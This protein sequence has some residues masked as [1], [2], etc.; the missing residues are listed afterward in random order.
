MM[1]KNYF[2]F[3]LLRVLKKT[4]TPLKSKIILLLS[5][6]VLFATEKIVAQDFTVIALPDTQ[7]Y[8]GDAVNF[9]LFIDQ[10]QW[11]LD[12]KDTR[13]IV[14]V[15][16]LGDI[17][18]NS[19]ATEWN[20]AKQALLLLNQNDIAVG[21]APGNHDYNAIFANTGPAT[22]YDENLPATSAIATSDGFGITS[23]EAHEWY[24]G[25]MGGTNDAV[26]ADDPANGNYT[27]RLWKNNYI[28]F[29]AGGMDFINIAL[30]FDFPF[31]VEE[32][33][34]DVLT[35]FPNRRAI[36][37][38]HQFLEDNNNVSTDGAQQAVL[39]NIL[40]DHCNVFL[41]LSAHNHSGSDATPG[42]AYRMETNSCGEPVHLVMSDY[43]DRPNDGDGWLRIMTFRPDSDEIDVETYS[44]TR[45]SGTGDYETDASSQFTLAYDMDVVSTSET[46]DISVN[47]ESDDAEE[48][49]SSGEVLLESSDLEIGAGNGYN[50][51][52]GTFV[53][54]LVG[55]RFQNITVPEGATITN[56]YIQFTAD[57]AD[58]SSITVSIAGE[59]S[60]N[61][62]TFTDTDGD[63]S[64][65]TTTTNS[66]SWSPDEWATAGDAGTAQQTSDITAI[67]QEIIGI[68]GWSSGNAMAFIISG[69]TEPD[70]RESESFD[71]TA[72]PTLHIEYT[73]GPPLS[74]PPTVAITAPTDGGTIVDGTNVSITANATDDVGVTQVAFFVD[75][76]LIN[77]DTSSPYATTN[78]FADGEHTIKAVSTDGD[79]QTATDE[80]TI[81]IGVVAETFMVQVSNDEDDAEENLS[82]NSVDNGSS[83]LEMIF[84]DG[85]S[86]DFDQEVGMRFQG[87]TVP[88]GATITSAYL[89]FTSD[90]SSGGDGATALTIHGQDDDNPDAFTETDNNITNRTKT[91]A[92]VAWNPGT[93]ATTTTYQSADISTILQEIV[94]R[95]GW[96][97]GNSMVLIVTGN[98]GDQVRAESHDGE[99]GGDDAPRLFIEY[100]VSVDPTINISG[101]PLADF[102]AEPNVDSDEQSYTVAGIN[103]T[104][105]IVINAP[106]DFQISLTSGSGFVSSLNLSPTSNVVAT[107][108]IFVKFNRA[109]EGNSNGNITHASAGA[110]QGD[111]AVNGDAAIAPTEISFQEG[112][113]NGYSNTLD[114]FLE[115]GDDTADNSATTTLV[116]DL[117]PE[118]HG[119]LRFDAIFGSGANQIPLGATIQNASLDIEVS[120][121]GTGADLHRMLQTWNDTDSWSTWTD[122]INAD[123][124]EAETTAQSSSSGSDV[125]QSSIDVTA[126]LQAWSNG[127]S[128]FGWAWLPPATDNSWRFDSSENTDPPKLTVAYTLPLVS[129]TIVLSETSLADF[130]AEPNIDSDEQSYT[131]SGSDLTEDI[132][133]N[134]PSDFQISLTSGSGFVSSLNVSPTGNVVASTTIFVK[135]NRTTE[136]NSNGNITH[137]SASASQEDVA[138]NG[139]AVTAS[140][141][142]WIAYNDL[143]NEDGGNATNVTEHDFENSTDEI[144]SDYNSGTALN[145]EM[146]VVSTNGEVRP[147][148]GE[149]TNTASDAYLA[150]NGIVNQTGVYQVDDTGD[151]STITFN[152]LDPSK[153]YEI[154]L[155]TNRDEADYADIRYT[156]VTIVDAATAIN[157]SSTGVIVNSN[158]SVSFSTGYNTLNGY[159]AKWTGIT[160][161][162]NG[163]F[164][165]ASVWDESLGGTDSDNTKGYAMS[166]FKLEQVDQPIS[167]SPTV[168][169][170]APAEGD[171]IVDGTNVSITADATDDVSVS[172]VEF[173]VDDVSIGT[174]TSSPYAI[175]N[176]FADGGHTIKAVSTDGEGQTATDEITITVG[177]VSETLDIAVSQESDDAEEKNT[178]SGAEEVLLESSDLELC[179][180]DR[181]DSDSEDYESQFVGIRFQNITIPIGATI[182]NAY[183]QFTADGTDSDAVSIDIAGE[184]TNN[185][186]TFTE[187]DGDISTR[188]TTT[189]TVNWSPPEWANEGDAGAAQQTSDISDIVQ[190]IINIAGWNS[191]NAMTF[192]LSSSGTSKREP[193]SYDGSS[194]DA[195]SLHIEYSTVPPP[196]D[197][198]TVAIT[199]PT[200]GDTIINGTN[201]SITAD[202]TDDVSISQVEFFVDDV[203][204]G[205]DTSSPYATTNSFADG[206]HTIKAVSTDGDGQTAT[207]EITIT[208]GAVSDVVEIRVNQDSDDAE[209]NVDS[210]NSDVGAVDTGSSDLEMVYDSDPQG[211]SVDAFDQEVGI[212]F[213][214]IN[215]PQGATITSAYIEFVADESSGGGT[216]ASALIVYGQADDNPSTFEET[217]QNI[218][219]RTKTSASV[220]WNPGTWTD[221]MPYQTS[222]LTSIVQEIA[223]RGGWSSGNSMA[224]IITGNSGDQVRAESHDGT[225]EEAPLLHIEYT[226]AP[227]PVISLT[228]DSPQTIVVGDSYAELGATATDDVDGDISG[229]IVIN[230]TT[231]DTN[232]VGSYSVTYD[233]SNSAGVSAIQVTRTVNVVAEPTHTLSLNVSLQGQ[234]D[235]SGNYI[236]ALYRTDDLVNSAY[237]LS[238]ETAD[239]LGNI[240]ISTP[241]IEGSYKIL[242]KCPSYLARVIT[243]NLTGDQTETIPIL[244]AGDVNGDGIVDVNDYTLLKGNF[245]QISETV[246][247]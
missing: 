234:T 84:D 149:I 150:F 233:V 139:D 75:D 179:Y 93:W 163:S 160:T 124:V 187:T 164:S 236:I 231:I 223:D 103:L 120:N 226:T 190:E 123:G 242:V 218:T 245:F 102:S 121:E 73:T 71:G 195:P 20:R 240:T 142:N 215:V 7:H 113:V 105:D 156:N 11:V 235:F 107:T 12:E 185:S 228:G 128:N 246:N 222:D 83:D 206:E 63:I 229:S 148:G 216:G 24:G 88:V 125:G 30:E 143:N 168:A 1:K 8:S 42:E 78:S 116:V 41:I 172:Q 219:G 182:T 230:A 23:Y 184:A 90:A 202:A 197:S 114:T 98:S 81:T 72:A 207:D 147:E 193:E 220:S 62:V 5:I 86:G 131:V 201:V 92:S 225:S 96:V 159:V 155:T 56:A 167:T 157:E 191:G 49:V 47:Q 171:T 17:V 170:T 210:A 136:G 135:F 204:I 27:N 18:N 146:T 21:V 74:A 95:A 212:R 117:S 180:G 87:L 205:T 43:Q 6:F 162:V 192:V 61:A 2:L 214:G 59:A 38:T 189:S 50:V 52:G 152:N 209:E 241:I 243:V 213:Q 57:E 37:S 196:S 200:D 58:N 115:S 141:S 64:S 132:V 176:S 198:P 224:F 208:I 119:L 31:E 85:F 217:D 232:T 66:V 173:F 118:I 145:A 54:Q 237:D 25:Y 53:N 109:T 3:S 101:T 14:L 48:G 4:F 178:V 100:T 144:L 138:V 15:D 199:A 77:T 70:K 174:D 9:Q 22:L 29:S 244:I 140:T 133:I 26:T 247:D 134:A 80:I 111:V 65:R 55:V 28:L 177:A 161:G 19:N 108:T 239:A 154:T 39:T 45:N 79:G 51:N 181:Y 68:S 40:A 10:T 130:S 169:I 127:A 186:V 69:S 129:P 34:D 238:T 89:E 221:D 203:S 183:I 104:E 194:S 175:T 151:I 94:D 99:N 46:L 97:N 137:T 44:P 158:E 91:T 126:D 188:T 211:G 112:D 60:N 33:V 122:G 67:V 106:S 227:R 153:E 36:I 16:H 165:I 32:W 110:S 166:A 35:A 76:V 13:N 82:D